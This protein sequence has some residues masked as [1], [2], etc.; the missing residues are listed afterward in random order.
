MTEKK[1]GGKS[2]LIILATV[3]LL[4]CCIGCVVPEGSQVGDSAPDFTLSTLDGGQVTLSEL[5]G[6]LVMLVFWTTG[7]YACILQMPYL[8]SASNEL[9]DTVEFINIDIGEN[10]YQVRQT[11][12]YH[13]FSLPVALDSDVSVTTAYNIGPTPT[14]IIID[15][16]GVIRYIRKGA[17]TSA[18]EIVSILNGIE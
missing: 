4:L 16:D 12:D 1:C 10:S 17:F 5:S 15:E 18:S 6:K 7:C 2:I 14:N 8:E 3:S 9:G 13:G 11:V